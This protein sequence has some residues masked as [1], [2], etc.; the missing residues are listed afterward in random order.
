MTCPDCKMCFLGHEN[1]I[2]RGADQILQL[3]LSAP[4]GCAGPSFSEVMLKVNPS[5]PCRGP[6]WWAAAEAAY[7]KTR[8]ALYTAE[9]ESPVVLMQNMINQVQMEMMDE[10]NTRNSIRAF[11]IRLKSEDTDR[12]LRA[13]GEELVRRMSAEASNKSLEMI[14]K[15]WD[16]RAHAVPGTSDGE[17]EWLC[18]PVARRIIYPDETAT[19]QNANAM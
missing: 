16:E 11:L 3:H 13:C 19:L 14:T 12:Y 18:S 1:N 4:F 6:A 8:C 15:F 9:G 2:H 17:V 5:L 10:I 7:G